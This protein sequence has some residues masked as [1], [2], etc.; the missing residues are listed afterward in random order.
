M[1]PN[2]LIVKLIVTS[3]FINAGW[4]LILPIYAIFVTEQIEGGSLEMV[5]LAVGIFWLAKATSQP[6]FAY[7]MDVVRGEHDD[8][9]FLL[10]GTII[11]ALIPLIYIFAFDVWHIFIL[12]AIRGFGFAMVEPTLSGVF[13]RHVDKNWEAYAW[14]LHS[15]SLGFAYGFSAIFGGMIASFLGFN[16]LFVLISLSSF[17]SLIIAYL[18]IRRDPWLKD[19]TEED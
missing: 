12:E 17:L 10:K 15:A 9:I 19:G 8:M 6:F 14:G 3:F 13:T 11:A 7:K 16:T 1:K 5:G 2:K 18:A 4:G